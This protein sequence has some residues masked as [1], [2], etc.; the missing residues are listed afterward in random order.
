MITF[1]NFENEL[2]YVSSPS[3]HAIEAHQYFN[4]KIIVKNSHRH[5]VAGTNLQGP[6]CSSGELI[7]HTLNTKHQ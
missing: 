3:F 6:S 2:Q 7:I 4:V 1:V 5:T